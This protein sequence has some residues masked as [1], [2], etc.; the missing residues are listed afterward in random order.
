[1]IAGKPAVFDLWLRCNKAGKHVVDVDLSTK[2]EVSVA[3]GAALSVSL[4]D[5]ALLTRLK[6]EVRP[7]SKLPRAEHALTFCLFAGGQRIAV[8]PAAVAVP[9]EWAVIGPFPSAPWEGVDRPHAPETEFVSDAVYEGKR[10]KV[11][12]RICPNAKCLTPFGMIDFNYLYGQTQW[13]TAYARTNVESGRGREVVLEVTNDDMAKVWLNG[14]HVFT[15]RQAAPSSMRRRRVRVRLRKGVNTILAKC[16]QKENYWEFGLRL[17]EMDGRSAE[18][19]GAGAM[20][21]RGR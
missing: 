1:M 17:L 6:V 14:E 20:D 13:A 21:G 4:P 15:S 16:C 11:R 8:L 18:V 12:W 7:S 5:D 10:G 19:R 9:L 2:A 3:P